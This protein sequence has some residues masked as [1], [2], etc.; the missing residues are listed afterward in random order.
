MLGSHL[1]F[2]K[3]LPILNRNPKDSK[4]FSS[5]QL[6]KSAIKICLEEDSFKTK[7]EIQSQ[8]E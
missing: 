3:I 4:F 2:W 8:D 1:I 7:M 5:V 6:L